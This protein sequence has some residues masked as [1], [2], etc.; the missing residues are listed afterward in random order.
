MAEQ[1]ASSQNPRISL[2]PGGGGAK[3]FVHAGV[4]REL[5]EQNI[6]IGS[7][8]ATSIGAIL[9]GVFA[10]NFSLHDE[11]PLL[12]RQKKAAIAVEDVARDTRFEEL[13]DINWMSLLRRGILKGQAIEEWLRTQFLAPEDG[14]QDSMRFS[15]LKFDFTVTATN[16][17][18]GDSVIL[19]DELTRLGV[20]S[21]LKN[22]V[23]AVISLFTSPRARALA[24]RNSP[25]IVPSEH[26]RQP[27]N[28]H[29]G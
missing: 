22:D 1:P 16:A 20:S 10:Y 12:S 13:R 19:R 2:A 5:T 21:K 3:G 6:E 7:I 24:R 18:T 17:L 25:P 27:L 14:R 9:G 29:A 15:E 8:V 11:L 23:V 4:L 28:S 26:G